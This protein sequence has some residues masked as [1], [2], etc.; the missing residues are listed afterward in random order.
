MPRPGKT[1]VQVRLVGVT[2]A[3]PMHRDSGPGNLFDLA[4]FVGRFQPFHKGHLMVVREALARARHVLIVL[5]SSGA[6]RR[7]DHLP[8]TD[9]ERTE[10]ILGCLTPEEQARV[11]L[12]GCEDRGNITLWTEAVQALADET[13]ARIGLADQARVTL[14]GHSKDRSSYYL[15]AFPRWAAIDVPKQATA[16]ATE[17]RQAYFDEHQARVD[18]YLAGPAKDALPAPVLAWLTAFRGTPAYGDLVEE[19]AFVKAYRRTW[20]AAPYPPIFVTADA[21]VVQGANILLIQRRA[22]P[23]KGLWALP[24]GFVEQDEFLADAALRELRE[25]TRLRVPEAIL[26]GSIVATRVFDAPYRSMRGRTITHATLFH[27]QPKA[28]ERRPGEPEMD[29]AKLQA[30]LALPRVKGADDAQHARWWPLE[31]VARSMMFEDHYA[32]IQTMK[33]LIPTS[34]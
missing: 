29:P 18:A 2:M 27:L 9:A 5:G 33:A 4:V 10:M 30:A 13:L 25:E 11:S 12:R 1:R 32:V 16:S 21:V 26:R 14:I 17:I 7:P 31:K 20:D 34:E 24:G 19:W 23:G 3:N 6:A 8:F 15:R 28:P 22:R